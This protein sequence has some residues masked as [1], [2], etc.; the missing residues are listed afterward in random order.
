MQININNQKDWQ[1]HGVMTKLLNLWRCNKTIEI[2]SHVLF[3]LAANRFEL[4]LGFYSLLCKYFS[5]FIVRK[6]KF[7]SKNHKN[8]SNF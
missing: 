2:D 8:K 6:K 5:Y 3:K 4:A 7:A 1:P